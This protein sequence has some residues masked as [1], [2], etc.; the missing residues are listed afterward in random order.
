MNDPLRSNQP[1]DDATE[2]KQSF[3]K[4]PLQQREP[5]KETPWEPNLAPLDDLT[6]NRKDFTPKDAGKAVSC[7]PEA[8]PYQSSAP[9]DGNTTHNADYVKWQP[10]ERFQR[11]VPAYQKPAGE[12]DMVTTSNVDYT[13]KLMERQLLRRPQ[14]AQK[15]PGKFDGT[16]NY[17]VEYLKWGPGERAH[18]VQKPT[19]Q[20]NDA[21]FEGL[22]TYQRDFVPKK[23]EM[24][25]SLKPIDT[26]YRSN[27]PLDDATEYNKEFI[28]KYVPPCPVP[29]VESGQDVGFAYSHQDDVGH[30]WHDFVANAAHEQFKSGKLHGVL[31]K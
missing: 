1:F 2:N 27:A 13:K 14:E 23:G 20:P 8:N 18:P 11:D 5:K 25:K 19:Y 9:F 28:K 24:A 4:H 6:T 3:V 21:P 22:P 12:M 15:N 26:G 16:T 30:K 31:V 17:Q 10:G 7:K 29:F